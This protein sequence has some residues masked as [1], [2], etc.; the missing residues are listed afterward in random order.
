[1]EHFAKTVNGFKLLIIFPKMSILDVWQ[2]F[3]YTSDNYEEV[4][5]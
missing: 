1:M 3:E 4:H 2:S 5:F